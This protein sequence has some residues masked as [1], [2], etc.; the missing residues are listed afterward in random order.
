MCPTL[1]VAGLLSLSPELAGLLKPPA[2]PARVMLTGTPDGRVRM[3]GPDFTAVADQIITLGDKRGWEFVGTE[4]SP[5]GLMLLPED[6]GGIL[7]QYAGKRIIYQP[8][9]G[10]VHVTG[11]GKH[12]L[13]RAQSDGKK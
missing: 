8:D 13:K 4:Q 6:G 7:G 10:V 5:A 3:I 9:Q 12:I 11:S 1:L 2:P